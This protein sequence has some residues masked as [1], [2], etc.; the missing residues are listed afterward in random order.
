MIYRR[1]QMNDIIWTGN[2]PNVFT[3]NAQ[4]ALPD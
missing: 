2:V 4:H 3:L 1:V